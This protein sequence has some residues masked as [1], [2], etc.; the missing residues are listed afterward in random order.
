M[1]LGFLVFALSIST[2]DA[3]HSAYNLTIVFHRAEQIGFAG[4]SVDCVSFLA[5]S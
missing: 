1:R 5:V 3:S 4:E 2:R